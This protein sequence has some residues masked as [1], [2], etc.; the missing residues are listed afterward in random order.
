VGIGEVD[1]SEEYELTLRND[2]GEVLSSRIVTEEEIDAMRTSFD[3]AY[4]LL[5]GVGSNAELKNPQMWEEGDLEAFRPL[6]DKAQAQ[7]NNLYADND[8]VRSV[9]HARD[10][11]ISNILDEAVWGRDLPEDYDRMTAMEDIGRLMDESE[12]LESEVKFIADT[13]SDKFA[14]EMVEVLDPRSGRAIVDFGKVDTGYE[15]DDFEMQYWLEDRGWDVTIKS[16][17][18]YDDGKVRGTPVVFEK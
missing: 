14:V 11:A 2:E 10:I 8:T 9:E 15:L 7:A 16:E 3:E 17:M 12:M 6:A 4:E 13:I 18:T 1:M 5:S